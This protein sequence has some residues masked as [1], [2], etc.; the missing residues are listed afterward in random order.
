MSRFIRSQGDLDGACYLYTV[1]NCAQ[2][3][4]GRKIQQPRWTRLVEASITPSSFLGG[5]GTALID[6]QDDLLRELTAS[7]LSLLGCAV[8]VSCVRPTDGTLPRSISENSAIIL[9]DGYHWYCVVDTSRGSAYAACSAV[10]QENPR[11]YS[12]LKSPRLQR[13]YN[14]EIKAG[15]LKYFRNRAFLVQLGRA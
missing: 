15:D 12:E 4:L 10:W 7:Y 1:F 13:R 3:L 14:L 6:Q 8:T 9:D 2:T 5:S 11:N